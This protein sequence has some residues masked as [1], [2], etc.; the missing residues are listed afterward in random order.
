MKA[1]DEPLAPAA[2]ICVLSAGV[3]PSSARKLPPTAVTVQ[4]VAAPVW[5][6]HVGSYPAAEKSGMSSVQLAG[7]E[8]EKPAV[9]V[10]FTV[11]PVCELLLG[12]CKVIGVD[13]RP[14]R[15]DMAKRVEQMRIALDFF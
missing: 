11:R 6:P 10:T 2:R 9:D 15:L 3:P 4:F 8:P 12:C 7:A 14:G 5:S 1:L 13:R